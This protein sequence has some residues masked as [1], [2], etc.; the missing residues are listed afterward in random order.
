M[1]PN[2]NIKGR[3]KLPMIQITPNQM[4]QIA[5]MRKNNNKNKLN[6]LMNRVFKNSQIIQELK[7]QTV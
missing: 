7:G 6:K 1:F 5:I 2:K 4:N 3:E